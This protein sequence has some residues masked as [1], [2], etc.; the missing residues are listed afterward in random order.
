M[1]VAEKSEYG[2]ISYRLIRRKEGPSVNGML[3]WRPYKQHTGSQLAVPR[4]DT[5]QRSLLGKVK[6]VNLET[7]S[8]IG[9]SLCR[10]AVSHWLHIKL[11]A[12][13]LFSGY[14]TNKTTLEQ[15]FCLLCPKENGSQGDNVSTKE[16]FIW[17]LG[18]HMDG[19]RLKRTEFSSTI[20]QQHNIF[21]SFQTQTLNSS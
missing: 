13:R 11:P 9:F 20:L 8:R 4:S 6:R 12:Q 17:G 19:V 18:K 1:S 10:R 2:G 5:Q 14:G 21:Y 16:Y 3:I 7:E 15:N